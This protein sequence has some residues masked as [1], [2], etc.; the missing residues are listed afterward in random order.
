MCTFL[1]AICRY[2]SQIKDTVKLDFESMK[3]QK[4]YHR[5][6]MRRLTTDSCIKQ[7]GNNLDTYWLWYRKEENGDWV[8][9][10]EEV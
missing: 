3:I 1:N 4:S 8:K 10:G 9:Y 7:Q 2:R 6:D 5:A